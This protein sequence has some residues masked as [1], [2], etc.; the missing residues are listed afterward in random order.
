MV[1]IGTCLLLIALFIIGSNIRKTTINKS[2]PNKPADYVSIIDDQNQGTIKKLTNY[3]WSKPLSGLNGS[4]NNILTLL[5]LLFSEETAVFR[6]EVD[7]VILSTKEI[8]DLKLTTLSTDFNKDNFQ[9]LFDNLIT[10]ETKYQ[11]KGLI[12]A[13]THLERLKVLK[14]YF[15]KYQP[16]KNYKVPQNAK[17]I[18][19]GIVVATNQLDYAKI[20]ISRYNN[21]FIYT[22][23]A[24]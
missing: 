4:E 3:A 10:I 14:N 22:T 2:N 9:K 13:S 19:G 24:K 8:A 1:I 15:A 12:P 23:L 20:L 7:G 18:S 17:E 6:P 16:K 11:E 21:W 5:L